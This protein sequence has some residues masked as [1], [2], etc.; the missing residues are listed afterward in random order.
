MFEYALAKELAS[1]CHA[2]KLYHRIAARLDAVRASEANPFDNRQPKPE[3]APEQA[4][5]CRLSCNDHKAL[6][7]FST[8]RGRFEDIQFDVDARRRSYLVHILIRIRTAECINSSK[9]LLLVTDSMD[10]QILHARGLNDNASHHIEVSLEDRMNG[11]FNI[12]MLS[13]HYPA[14]FRTCVAVMNAS[15]PV[16]QM[17]DAM[18]EVL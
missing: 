6:L 2:L 15:P 1:A 18:R 14:V 10:H 11:F 12:C 4:H 3:T 7:Y 8:E 16:L 17:P 9:L 5:F 13:R